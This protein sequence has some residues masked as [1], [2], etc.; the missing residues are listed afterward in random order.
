MLFQW[1]YIAASQHPD[2][3][4]LFAIPNAGGYTGGY[5]SNIARVRSMLQE[6][7]KPGI[8]DIFCAVPHNGFSGLFIELK[9]RD[10][11]PSDV[12]AE[13]SSWLIALE[14]KGYCVSVCF[15]ADDA[16]ATVKAYLG[17]N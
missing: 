16:I 3:G 8:P 17:I 9:R 15:G 14:M 6:G 12:S 13:Q 4:F 7:V 5:R 2:L 10:G 11:R 1:A